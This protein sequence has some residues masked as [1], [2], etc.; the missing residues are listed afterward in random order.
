MCHVSTQRF[1]TTDSVQFCKCKRVTTSNHQR[2]L[3]TQLHPI[4]ESKALSSSHTFRGLRKIVILYSTLSHRLHETADKFFELEVST[5][6]ISFIAKSH[7]FRDFLSCDS[8]TSICIFCYNHPRRKQ[9]NTLFHQKQKQQQPV[10][11][12]L[13]IFCSRS[14]H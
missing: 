5:A 11:F 2:C 7:C 9:R 4:K 12:I 3:K 1:K 6:N 10:N 14:F 13:E 8:T